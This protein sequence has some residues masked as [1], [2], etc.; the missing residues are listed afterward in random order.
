M[1]LTDDAV[2]DPTV[3]WIGCDVCDAWFHAPRVGLGA[4]EANA[5]DDFQVCAAR[6]ARGGVLCLEWPPSLHRTL[7]LPLAQA[8][9]LTAEVA[10]QRDV[11]AEMNAAAATVAAEVEA[12]TALQREAEAWSARFEAARHD[13][14][15]ADAAALDALLREAE[16]LEVRPPKGAGGRRRARE[17]EHSR[18]RTREDRRWPQSIFSPP[19][20]YRANTV[21]LSACC[22]RRPLALPVVSSSSANHNPP[23]LP[24]LATAT[25]AVV[26]VPTIA[27]PVPDDAERKHKGAL[28][29]TRA[30][31]PPSLPLSSPNPPRL[32]TSPTPVGRV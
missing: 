23:E 22:R 17:A 27:V 32:P 20:C 19:Q 10:A 25:V 12:I 21:D 4:V 13:G 29:P 24:P 16:A 7:R 31:P 5:L 15:T 2:D 28:C 1:L 18:G 8:R 3:T 9:E 11:S 6:R 26:A 14:T 30:L